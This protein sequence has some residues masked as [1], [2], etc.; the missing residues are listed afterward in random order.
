MLHILA[1]VLG[2]VAGLYDVVVR[3][4]PTVGNYS[5]LHKVIEILAWVSNFLNVKKK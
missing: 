4:I 5:I 2:V 1:I 3:L